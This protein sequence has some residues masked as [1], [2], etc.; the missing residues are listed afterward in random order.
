[1][2]NVC[3][4]L[5]LPLA[6]HILLV[7]LRDP[8]VLMVPVLPVHL[9]VLPPGTRTLS[10]HQGEQSGLLPNPGLGQ[11]RPVQESERSPKFTIPATQILASALSAEQPLVT[12]KIAY[13]TTCI[14]S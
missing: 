9:L 10:S 2:V 4:G 11:Q 6:L 13:R 7:L 1:M 12:E 3:F 14:T 5:S 8:L